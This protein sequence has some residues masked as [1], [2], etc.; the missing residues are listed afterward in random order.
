[1]VVFELPTTSLFE[2]ILI[3]GVHMAEICSKSTRIVNKLPIIFLLE[4]RLG[5]LGPRELGSAV[6]GLQKLASKCLI[7]CNP[8][9][10][11]ISAQPKLKWTS[12]CPAKR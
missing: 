6:G 11:K 4:A 5:R 7:I 2:G 9:V 8:F 10:I 12:G 3:V 1:M